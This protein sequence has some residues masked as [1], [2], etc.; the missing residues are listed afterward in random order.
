MTVADGYAEWAGFYDEMPNPMI[1]TEEPAVDDILSNLEPGR[2][3]D[4]AC[5]TGRQTRRLADLGWDAVG[6]DA[7]PEILRVARTA[8][9]DLTFLEGDIADLPFD[10]DTFDLLICSL[11]LTH[12]EDL[13]P[14]VDEFARVV[15]PA[16]SLILTDIHPLAVTTGAHALYGDQRF[17]RN[18]IHRHADYLAAFRRAGLQ[19]VD[20]REPVLPENFLDDHDDPL[21]KLYNLAVGGLPAVLI[22]HCRSI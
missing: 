5:G 8:R 7:S 6:V 3:L 18:Q 10:D 12:V 20:C 22:W 13:R 4:V 2:A 9:P 21:A 19:V 17:I 15:T 16:G 1:D 11:A 14:A